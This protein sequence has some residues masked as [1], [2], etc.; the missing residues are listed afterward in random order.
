[1][2]FNSWTACR[3]AKERMKDAMREAEQKRLIRAA[4]G[5]RKERK[6]R[7]RVTLTLKSLL[8]IFT[9]RRV[10]ELCRRSPSTAS[11]PTWKITNQRYDSGCACC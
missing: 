5:P 3:L 8:A 2:L 10:D 7:L 1:M 9:D 4:K 11:S 6:W